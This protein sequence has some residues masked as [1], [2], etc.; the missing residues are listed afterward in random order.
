MLTLMQLPK[1]QN[2]LSF[3]KG[4]ENDFHSPA[5]FLPSVSSYFCFFPI[6]TWCHLIHFFKS[7]CK[8]RRIAISDL[9]VNTKATV[10]VQIESVRIIRTKKGDQM[11]FLN[12]TDGINKLDVTLFPETYFY[13]KDK[14]SEGGLFYLDGRTQER[15]GRIQ[16]ILSN[17]EEA[18]TE[19]FWILLENHDKDIEVSRILAKYP[20]HIPVIIRYQGSKETIVSQK[21]RVTKN[22]E[23]IREL[24]PYV[25]K[26]VL[27]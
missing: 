5:S 25:L 27:R 17:M 26:T 3:Q 24:A 18:S 4:Q 19:R 7:F 11:A 2:K 22:E 23:L 20:G 16:L 6:F 8:I 9:A 13:N 15:D 21:Y 12:V 14:L 1:Q 10:L